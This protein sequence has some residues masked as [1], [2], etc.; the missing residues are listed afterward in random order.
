[1]N[2]QKHI[3]PVLIN[4][5]IVTAALSLSSCESKKES[6]PGAAKVKNEILSVEKLREILSSNFVDE[7]FKNEY[8]QKWIE[9][10]ILF[11]KAVDDSIIYS[12]KFK[13]LFE[14]TKKDL[15]GAL[16]LQNYY[17]SNIIEVTDWELKQHYKEHKAEY[18]LNEDAFI[19]RDAYFSKFD[20]AVNFRKN[21]LRNNWTTVIQQIED[22]SDIIS[23]NEEKLFY[24][25]EISNPGILRVIKNLNEHELSIVLNSEPN[26]F[27]IVEL[28]QKLNEGDIPEFEYVKEVVEKR[29]KVNKRKLLYKELIESLYSKYNVKINK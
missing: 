5:L 20:K 10:E 15:A 6:F 4:L 11:Q 21:V 14:D 19:I 26:R 29:L 8:I 23:I 25:F 22:T 28:V 2:L 7:S 12:A 18:R 3:C 1:M 24:P 16:V 13:K 17:S 9:R 27:V